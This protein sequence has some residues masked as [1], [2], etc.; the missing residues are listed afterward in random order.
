MVHAKTGLTVRAHPSDLE[1]M[2]RFSA[3]V[4]DR[5]GEADGIELVADDTVSPGG[6]VVKSERTEVDA[7]LDTQIAEIVSLLLGK[8]AQAPQQDTVA[9]EGASDG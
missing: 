8:P 7:T 6:C 2:K 4:L 5:V 1:A 9:D 3:S